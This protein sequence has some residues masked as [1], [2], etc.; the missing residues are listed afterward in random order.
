MTAIVSVSFSQDSIVFGLSDGRTITAPLAWY[1][2]LERCTDA[3]R[4]A[5]NI[6]SHG[7]L[8]EWPALGRALRLEKLLQVPAADITPPLDRETNRFLYEQTLREE[9]FH[10]DEHQKRVAFFA[11]LISALLGATVAGFFNAKS[12]AHYAALLTGPILMFLVAGL[13]RDAAIRFYQRFLEAISQ[14]AKLEY[15]L[16]MYELRRP[17]GHWFESEPLVPGRHLDA[18]KGH[19]EIAHSKVKRRLARAWSSLAEPLLFGSAIAG[20]PAPASDVTYASSTHFVKANISRG[21]N[22]VAALMFTA[23]QL[24]SVA[25]ATLIAVVGLWN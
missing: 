10:L 7:R 22:R 11:G 4:S 14:R 2:F 15:D 19:A 3:E 25:L 17:V 9:Q 12:D 21:Y 13:G 5:F 24:V 18:R 6:E 20:R 8:I 1:P 16:N 23:V